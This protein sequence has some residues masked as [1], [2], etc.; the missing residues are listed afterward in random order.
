LICS[1]VGQSPSRELGLRGF[2]V[3][4]DVEHAVQAQQLDDA[5]YRRSRIVD[6]DRTMAVELAMNAEQGADGG[7]V[8]HL[9]FRQVD[10]YGIEFL[11]TDIFKIDLELVNIAGV[12]TGDIDADA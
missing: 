10:V 2:F 12:K 9:H 4:V 8:D 11:R 5:E 1:A 6:T 3:Y 7:T